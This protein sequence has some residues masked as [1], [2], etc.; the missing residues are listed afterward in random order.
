MSSSKDYGFLTAFLIGAG[1]ASVI[2][3][4]IWKFKILDGRISY[5]ESYTKTTLKD[6]ER[7]I[8]NLPRGVL[9]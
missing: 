9:N 4:I 7:E 1:S 8:N 2:S 6:I 3:C 5:L